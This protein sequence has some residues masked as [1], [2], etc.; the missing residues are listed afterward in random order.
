LA[1][2]DH[3][4]ATRADD[5]KALARADIFQQEWLAGWDDRRAAAERSASG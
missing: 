2:N 4:I 5:G 1:D 3:D